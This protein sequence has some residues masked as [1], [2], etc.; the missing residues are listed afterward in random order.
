M[1]VGQ[2]A[3]AVALETNHQAIAGCLRLAQE[4]LVCLEAVDSDTAGTNWI[5]E[6]DFVACQYGRTPSTMAE[7]S[8][9]DINPAP[10][11]RNRSAGQAADHAGCKQPQT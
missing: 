2:H 8:L 1:P 3:V 4:L 9:I 11:S 10:A 5:V 7:A 6:V